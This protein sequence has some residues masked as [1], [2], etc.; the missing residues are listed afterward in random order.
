MGATRWRDRGIDDNGREIWIEKR[1]H[2]GR[3]RV[4]Y[5]AQTNRHGPNGKYTRFEDRGLAGHIGETVD[6]LPMWEPIRLPP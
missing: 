1:D 6:H 2:L 4:W 5:L 3:R